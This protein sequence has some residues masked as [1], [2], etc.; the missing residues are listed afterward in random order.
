MQATCLECNNQLPWIID[1]DGSSNLYCQQCKYCV[2]QVPEF[3]RLLPD[4][5]GKQV[6]LS[7]WNGGIKIA[8]VG[9][10]D[11]EMMEIIN[12]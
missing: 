12:D 2:R 6:E 4:G 5:D 3:L 1:Y 8:A 9:L 11:E 7:C 10:L